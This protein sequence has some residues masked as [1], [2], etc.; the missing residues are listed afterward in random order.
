MKKTLLCLALCLPMLAVAQILEVSSIEKVNVPENMDSRVAGV[1]PDG[2]YILLTTNSTEGLQKFD[3]ASKE[4]TVLSKAPE[5]G[6]NVRISED[7]KQVLYRELEVGD[8][9]CCRT[10]LMHTDLTTKKVET[11]VPLTRE[12]GGYKIVG[13]AVLALDKMQLRKKAVLG[14]QV[15]KEAVPVLSIQDCQ[16]MITRG[17]ETKVLSP[18]GTDKSYIW[19]SISPD[20]KKICYFVVTEGCYVA[21]IDG[22]NPQFVAADLH[23]AKWYNN[24]VLIGMDDKDDGH[25]FTESTIVAYTLDGA[26]Q[27]LTD[28]NRHIAMYPFLSADGKKIAYSTVKGEVYLINIE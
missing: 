14:G 6:F 18:N 4:M 28:K 9:M 15:T 3:L 5:A 24:E 1:S 23:D 21:N 8:D 13:N 22:T 16:L 27:V 19:E 10:R 12:L 11:I 20:G 26:K 7:G 25:V 2:S 17:N